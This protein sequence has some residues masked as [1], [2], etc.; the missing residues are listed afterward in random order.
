MVN[1]GTCWTPL[2]AVGKNSKNMSS[3]IYTFATLQNMRL[4]IGIRR[5]FMNLKKQR[6]LN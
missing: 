3:K 4:Q 5:G 1:A 2:Q 6:Q